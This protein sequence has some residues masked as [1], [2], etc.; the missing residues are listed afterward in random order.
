MGLRDVRTAILRCFLNLLPHYFLFSKSFSCN[1]CEAPLK[2][3]K[4]RTYNE[5]KSFRCNTYKKLGR[6]S[7]CLC[8][9]LF[10][11][12]GNRSVRFFVAFAQCPPVSPAELEP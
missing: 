11:R 6:E 8:V 7:A 4:Q 2:C 10:H 3:C 1:T 5:A 9:D 12:L